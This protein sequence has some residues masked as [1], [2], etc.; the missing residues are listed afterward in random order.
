MSQKPLLKVSDLHISFP[1]KTESNSIVHGISFEIHKNEILGVVGESGSGKSIS[2]LAIMGLLDKNSSHTTGNILFEGHTINSLPEVALQK[3]RGNEISMIFQE[4]MSSL[5]PSLTCGYQVLEIIQ[6]HRKLTKKQGK[7][8]VISLFEKVKLPRANDM[9]NQYPHQ[10]SGGQKQRVMIALA[11]ACKPKLLIADEPTT[12][13]DVTVQKEIVKLL[14][15]IQKDTEM[16]ILFISHDLSLVAEICQRVVVMQH[17]NIVEQGAI[18][19]LFTN[20]QEEYT[21]AL[22]LSRPSL[23]KRLKTLPSVQ[24]FIEKTVDHTLYTEEERKEFH[25]EL[26]AKPPILK[27][28]N[29]KKHYLIQSKWWKKEKR[30]VKAVDGITFSVYD[31]ETLGLVGESGCGKSTLGRMLVGLEQVTEGSIFYKGKDITNFSPVERKKLS[32]EI[33]IIFQDPFSSLNPRIQ[34]GEAILEPMQTHGILSDTKS[35][36]KRVLE[37]LEKVGLEATHYHRYPH[38]F[39]GRQ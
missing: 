2:S 33:Q 8:A 23:D 15:E 10:L 7:Q 30:Y 6:Q 16:S 19:N 13:L 32:K 34:I 5:N 35:R 18:N 24:N 11:I 28:E 36:K 27:I 9:Y 22:L 1:S 12:A 4:P 20:P 38:E 31:G 37:L 3:I 29:L 14:L 25:K 21:K 26:Y 39:S 17:G